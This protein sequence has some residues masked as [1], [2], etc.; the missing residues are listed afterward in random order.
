M[1]KFLTILAILFMLYTGFIWGEIGV[2]INSMAHYYNVSNSSIVAC[3]SMFTLSATIMVISSTGIL[4]E[5][6]SLKKVLVMTSAVSI[7]GAIFLLMSAG[8][9]FL[10]IALFIFGIGYGICFALSY[11]FV[12]LT[13]DNLNRASRMA[14]ISFC[15]GIG[16]AVSPLIA[17]DMIKFGIN[18]QIVFTC[19]TI[20]MIPVGI[21]SLFMNFEKTKKR[22][23]TAKVI[24][25]MSLICELKSWPVTVY[26]MAL[27]L[28]I[29]E[30]A[31]TTMVTWV[32]VYGQGNL[33]L[34]IMHASQL[35][36]IFWICVIIGRIMAGF[37]LKKVKAEIYIIFVT[38]MSG[39][40]LT[41]FSFMDNTVIINFILM[42]LI[43]IGFSAL[44]STITSLGTTQLKEASPRLVSLL[45]G[46]GC[47]GTIMSPL[48]TSYIKSVWGL[49][50]VFLASAVFMFAI[51][52]LSFLVL[53]ING[54]KLIVNRVS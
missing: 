36:S 26:L 3:F 53:F 50:E 42:G 10:K 49:Q 22:D 5:Y 54:R 33:H 15:F 44:Y 29:Y 16:M 30:L 17:G 24:K 19:F 48:I 12:V 41:I 23:S 2:I 28:L 4:V 45:L 38:V 8:I 13:T 20:V 35:M 52:L 32:V 18:W 43:G 21:I 11:Y 7:I 31:E 40:L 1:K 9:I 25:K 37:A 14:I 46:T 6:L 51:T 39:I 47:V 34:T 27:G